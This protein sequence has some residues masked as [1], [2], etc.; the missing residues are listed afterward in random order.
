MTMRSPALTLALAG[1]LSVLLLPRAAEPCAVAP[2]PGT[3]VG[4]DAESAI[5]VWDEERKVEHFIRSATFSTSSQTADFGFL[6]PTP[7]QPQLGEVDEDDYFALEM[8]VREERRNVAGE[9]IDKDWKLG[10]VFALGMKSKSAGDPSV[11]VL[12]ETTV[13]G[14]RAAVLEAD[15]PRA[16]ASWLLHHEYADRPELAEWLEPYVKAGW[17]V[18]AFRFRSS[19]ST[20]VPT[21]AVRMSF[22]AERPFFPYRE[23]ADATPPPARSLRV[24]V[25]AGQRMEGRLETSNS[26][27]AAAWPG[28]VEYAGQLP[29]L[30]EL[31]AELMPGQSVPAGRWVTAFLDESTRR[32]PGELFF[33]PA[34]DRAAIA[35]PVPMTPDATISIELIVIVALIALWIAWIWRR[36]SRARA[37]QR[38]GDTSPTRMA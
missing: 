5:I 6:V 2:R 20:L 24:F 1:A 37:D 14:Y 34:T 23:P 29:L 25:V 8:H 27:A 36:R 18:T 32:P 4:I 19:G 15:D 22:A 13:A 26:S 31:L 10:C 12:E 17:K 30:P 11:R 9:L 21:G 38:S 35:L 28:R 7:T 3:Q 33:A 16:L